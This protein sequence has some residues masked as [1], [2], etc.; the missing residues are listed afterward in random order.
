MGAYELRCPER[1]QKVN[2]RQCLSSR[3]SQRSAHRSEARS[4][5]G[6]ICRLDVRL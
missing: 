4:Q 1:Q 3:P 5:V 2:H 6:R